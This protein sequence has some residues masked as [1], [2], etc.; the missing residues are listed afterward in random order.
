V[1]RAQQSESCGGWGPLGA[2]N[3]TLTLTLI[4][5]WGPL[6]APN[7]TLTLT[8]TLIGGWGPLGA[9]NPNSLGSLA[10]AGGPLEVWLGTHQASAS[11]RNAKWPHAAR[12]L[13]LLQ[14]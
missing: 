10:L 8:L 3:L 9:P 11:D 12:L 7:L 5:G 4:G 1:G 14:R 6:G 2:P 13:M